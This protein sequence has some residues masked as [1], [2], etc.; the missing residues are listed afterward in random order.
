MAAFEKQA[1]TCLKQWLNPWLEK[2]IKQAYH[3]LN[4]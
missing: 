4:S 1:G 3:L 2:R